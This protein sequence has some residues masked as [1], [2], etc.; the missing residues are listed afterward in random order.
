[1]NLEVK[2]GLQ[3]VNA[4]FYD[5]FNDEEIDAALNKMQL[6]FV[7]N[8]FL[9]KREVYGFESV[10]KRLDDLRGLVVRDRPLTPLQLD[11][12]SQ[13]AIL[14]PDYLYLIIDNSQT[15]WH[16]DGVD[17]TSTDKPEYI[18][19]V[20][21][22]TSE[23]TSDYYLTFEITQDTTPVV[24]H[25]R[26]SDFAN[27]GFD[28]PE[29]RYALVD[30]VMEEMADLYRK[31]QVTFQVYY[32]RYRNLYRPSTFFFV[33][34]DATMNGTTITF[35]EDGETSSG[36]FGALVPA[37]KTESTVTTGTITSWRTNRV[38]EHDKLHQVLT[39]A[40]GQTSFNSPV[41]S[42]DEQRLVV[43]RNKTFILKGVKISYI[44]KPNRISLHL[45]R[46]CELAEHT[47]P[48]IVDMTV[49]HLLERVE[50]SR[51]QTSKIEENLNE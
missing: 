1:M 38:I 25:F 40:F 35:T 41:S 34:Y 42:I 9:R 17:V 31:G 8:R 46:S 50:A 39:H 10:Q 51:Y 19:Q 14:P 44:R 26:F 12:E 43:F 30:L 15:V 6:R 47:H 29:E 37:P 7:N 33:S 36:V 22:K 18:A 27:T 5:E 32:E 20:E 11:D 45:N 24:T 21:L 3:K 48:E 2:L 28:S 4:N 13:Y 49:S 16:C 23:A